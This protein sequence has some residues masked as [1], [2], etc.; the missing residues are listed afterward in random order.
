MFIGSYGRSVD[1]SKQMG[2]A[3]LSAV[4]TLGTYSI[5]QVSYTDGALAIL[6]TK[7]GKIIW[8]DRKYAQGGSGSPGAMKAHIHQMVK[9]IPAVDI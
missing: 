2:Q 1:F 4:L 5:S 3:L 7:T 8:S 9:R 6:D